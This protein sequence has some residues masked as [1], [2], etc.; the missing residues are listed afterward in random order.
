MTV[1][2]GLVTSDAV[3]LGCDSVAS[4]TNYF[5]DPI[6]LPWVKGADGKHLKDANGKFSLSFD[7]DDYQPLVTNAW[8]GVTKMRILYI[9]SVRNGGSRSADMGSGGSPE[10]RQI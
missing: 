9:F 10:L 3:V 8:G 1:N 2:I 5:L 4:T 6:A 7:F